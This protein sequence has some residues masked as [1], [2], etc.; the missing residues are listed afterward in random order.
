MR[1]LW[2][3][4]HGTSGQSQ[5]AKNLVW[6]YILLV[7]FE[8]ALRKWVFPSLSNELLV[9][10]DPIALLLLIYGI[11]R[12][13]LW[14]FYSFVAIATGIFALLIT[15]SSTDVNLETAYFGSRIWY[16]YVPCFFVIGNI[17]TREDVFRVLRFFI[18]LSIPMTVFVIMQNN[19]PQSSWV[20]LGVGGN[21]E[22][23]GFAPIDDH[24][25]PS[26]I[27]AFVTLYVSYQVFVLLG[28][29]LYMVDKEVR[30]LVPMSPYII[31]VALVCY[32]I[33]IAISFSLSLVFETGLL[34][35]C[36]FFFYVIRGRGIGRMLISFII[37]II[38]SVFLLQNEY[39][40]KQVDVLEKRFD[41]AEAAEGDVLEGTLYDRMVESMFRFTELE[42]PTMGNGIG[43]AS[44]VGIKYLEDKN[45]EPYITDEEWSRIAWE[46]G[47]YIG[48]IFI[49]LR[50]LLTFH[51]LFRGI[52]RLWWR[53]VIPIMFIPPIIMW[54]PN[55]NWSLTTL[56][57]LCSLAVSFFI[58]VS[59][60]I[61]KQQD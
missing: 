40:Q 55:N 30:K 22:G 11:K 48:G 56:L 61:P 44:R 24:Y 51:L 1:L 60:Y 27:F 54:V 6:L 47:F 18:W 12:R 32:L 10:R 46:S 33:S 29:I 9:I 15:R 50:L 45:E 49:L 58:S 26:A 16:F 57:G 2:N 4:I 42:T 52:N 5:Y 59:N 35:L 36:T 34:R 38:T 14:G 37:L 53:D 7:V 8:G 23:S 43:I 39:V 3:P 20:N 19:S 21:E 31:Y 17:M 25:R 41:Q 28:L 13:M